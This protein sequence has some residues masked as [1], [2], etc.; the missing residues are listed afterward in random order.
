[1][2]QNC[3]E[4]KKCGREKGGAKAGEFGVCPVFD[5]ESANGINGGKNGGRICW[6]ISHTYCDGK[7]QGDLAEKQVVCVKCEVFKKVQ[8][9][10]GDNFY[11]IHSQ[12]K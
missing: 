12:E 2:K 10:E 4:I 7:K 1:M 8:D 3:W 11:L 5:R 9:E 6:A